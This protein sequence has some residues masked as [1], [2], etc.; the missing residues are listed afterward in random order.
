MQRIFG[1]VAICIAVAEGVVCGQA[2]AA[3]TLSYADLVGRL[4]DLEHLAVLPVPGEKCGQWSSYDRASKYDAKTGKYLHWDANGDGGGIIRQEGDRV[5]HG[6]DEGTG[7]HLADLV[8]GRREGTREDLS[9]R[10][11]S[12]RPSTCPLS[13]TLTAST[14]R[15]TTPCSPTICNRLAA[16][17]QNLYMPIPYQKSCK[18]VAE[19]GWGNYFHFIYDTFPKGTQVPTFSA[20]WRPK[21]P[22]LKRVN[23][24]FRRHSGRTRPGSG[25][26][27]KTAEQERSDRRRADGASCSNWR[28]RRA[29]TAIRVKM[30]FK[31]REDELAGAAEARPADHLGRRSRS[32]PSGARWAISSARRRART[33]TSRSRPA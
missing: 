32:R 27:E 9:R 25:K 20:R 5:G 10:A 30:S 6:R 17:G 29:I 16:S 26:G 11:G 22:A 7:L 2:W 4:T 18:I 23:D 24:F 21:T 31:D 12:S 15:S 33:S 19:K 28:A 3:E 13:T 14:P 1:L 8:G